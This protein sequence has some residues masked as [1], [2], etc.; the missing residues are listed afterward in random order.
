MII[1]QL[2][3]GL[4]NQLFQYA[5]GYS[6]AKHHKVPLKVDVR[7][8]LEVK[9]PKDTKRNYELEHLM[10]PPVIATQQEIEEIQKQNIIT[11]YFQKVLPPYRRKIYKEKAFEFDTNFWQ[12]GTN[13]Y[14][15][16]Y[17]QSEKY[18]TP[19]ITEVK[20]NFQLQEKLIEHLKPLSKALNEKESVSIH[21]RR[22][23]YLEQHMKDYHGVLGQ[24]YYQA[25][26]DTINSVVPSPSYFIFSDSAEWVKE[27]LKFNA[28][29]KFISGTIT[30]NHYEDFY[31]MSQC[32]HNIIANS[33][34][35]WWAAWLNSNPGRKVVA[36]IRW[37]N[38]PRLNTKDLIP[39]SWIRL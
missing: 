13:I 4:G 35:S 33:S 23:D 21:I 36:P 15:K 29:V 6:L 25:A 31:L 1:V 30:K 32:R 27:N 34:F 8:L 16:G 5:A 37:F 3:G 26:I 20:K 7:E 11:K 17:R 10:L 18:F 9:N 28:H 39:E 2:K 22:G 19:Y 24:E 12:A 14:L 38:K